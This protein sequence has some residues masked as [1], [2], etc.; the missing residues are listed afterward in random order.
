MAVHRREIA[1]YGAG[2]LRKAG[3]MPRELIQ[4][5][6]SQTQGRSCS[7]QVLHCKLLSE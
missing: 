4:E 6:P 7:V 5:V 2:D 3:N 1:D